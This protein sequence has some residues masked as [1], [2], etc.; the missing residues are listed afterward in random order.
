MVRPGAGASTFPP[1]RLFRLIVADFR[2]VAFFR[3]T[4]DEV[5]MTITREQC[6]AARALLDISQC[7][8]AKMSGVAE[9]TIANFENG[10]RQPRE[11]NLNALRATF[12]A[13][14]VEFVRGGAALKSLTE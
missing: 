4:R 1:G 10:L 2:Q 12:E 13:A 9:R 8:L 6:R 11:R 14:G 7:Q 5:A 3:Q